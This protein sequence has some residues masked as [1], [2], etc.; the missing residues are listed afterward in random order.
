MRHHRGGISI[1]TYSR[2]IT[3]G[4]SSR[5]R[6]RHAISSITR[7][8]NDSVAQRAIW[9]STT[10]IPRPCPTIVGKDTISKPIPR[11]IRMVVWG[12]VAVVIEV[13][14]GRMTHLVSVQ[15]PR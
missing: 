8:P 3:P 4:R 7:I 15:W 14:I 11:T 12:A 2:P 5:I 13:T 6:H 9:T 1:P 10:S